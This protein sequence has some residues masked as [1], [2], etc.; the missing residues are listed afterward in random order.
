MRLRRNSIVCRR[1]VAL[2]TDYLDGS[3]SRS[4]RTRFEQHLRGCPHCTEYLAQIRA[5]IRAVGHVGPDE[6][7]PQAKAD[8]VDLYRRWRADAL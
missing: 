4:E 1:A 7:Q 3:L 6:L 8:L 2:V 5:T